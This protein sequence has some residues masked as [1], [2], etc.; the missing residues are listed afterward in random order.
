MTLLIAHW[1]GISPAYS[2]IVL[3]GLLYLLGWRT[4]GRHFLLCSLLANVLYSLFYLPLEA[5]APL[6]PWILDVQPW[7]AIVGALFV[8]VGTGLCVLAGG[9]LSG[10][11]A[12][13][14]SV[15]HRTGWKISWV[16]LLSD[17][18][19]LLLSL[20][21]IPAER[22]AWSLLTVVLSGQ[23]IGWIV[24]LGTPKETANE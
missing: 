23:I 22:I 4:L 8:G 20:S 24:R 6:F 15:S 3:N 2:S 17:L 18:T 9:A 19:V 14:M 1:T 12:L 21:Y 7:C 16:Y 13:A 5:V 10:D 11:D